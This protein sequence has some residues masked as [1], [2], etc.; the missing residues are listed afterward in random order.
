MDVG[1]VG[2]M[3]GGIARWKRGVGGQGL[4]TA[5]AYAFEGVCDCQR[6][7]DVADGIAKASQYADAEVTRFTV[8]AQHG[9]TRDQLDR[10][11]LRKWIDGRDPHTGEARGRLLQRANNDLLFDATVNSPKSLSIAA[12]LDDDLQAGLDR[13]H[14]RIRDRAIRLW[15]REMNSRRGKDGKEYMPLAQIEVVELKH[16][17]SR[18]L[19]PHAHRHMWLNAK[20]LGNDGRWTSVDSRVLL[21]FQA[22]IN[23]EGD[24]AATSDPEWLALLASKGLTVD[25]DTGEIAELAHLTQPLSRRHQQI[26]M[27]RA[28]RLAQW[29]ADHPGMSPSPADL[30]AIDK[31]AWAHGRPNK[32]SNFDELSWRDTVLDEIRALDSDTAD[33][34]ATGMPSVMPPVLAGVPQVS[35]SDIDRF[36]VMALAQADQR[37]MTASARFAEWDV[38]AAA[39]RVIA[40]QGYVTTRDSLDR[41]IDDVTRHAL[42]HYVTDLSP[43]GDTPAH[44]RRFVTTDTAMLK[45]RVDAALAELARRPAT[46]IVVADQLVD[47]IADRVTEHGL[48]DA[49]RAAA[50]SIACGQPLVTV[51]GPAGAG[52]TSML[53]VARHLLQAQ[54]RRMMIVAPTKK[55][56]TVAA[57]E[58]GSFA[59][60]VHS[61][62]HQA[63]WR[64]HDDEA[65]RARWH[66]LSPGD[67]DPQ[68]GSPWQ[69]PDLHLGPDTTI[70]IDEAGMLDLH[71]AA[72][73]IE[74]ANE[75]GVNL[76]WVGDPEQV[77]PVGHSGAMVMAQRHARIDTELHAVHRFRNPDGSADT[78]WAALSKRL[79]APKSAEDA[80]QIAAELVA[81]DRV[82]VV[83]SSAEA[84]LTLVNAWLDSHGAGQT[85]AV[86]VSTNDEAQLINDAIQAERL[87]RESLRADRAAVGMNGQR[88]LVGDVVQT[89]RNDRAAEVENRA[90]WTVARITDAGIE[91]ES[92]GTDKLRRTITHAYAADAVHLGYATTAH[93]VQ[94]E[95]VQRAIVGP[96][97]TGGG[98]YVGLTRGKRHNEC[99]VVASDSDAAERELAQQMLRG[100]QE[101]T[102]DES[103]A[104]VARELAAAATELTARGIAPE[105]WHRRRHGQLTDLDSAITAA[106]ARIPHSHDEL[107]AMQDEADQ[108]DQS[109]I[110]MERELAV[111][112]STSDLSAR[113]GRPLPAPPVELLELRTKVAKLR[114]QLEVWTRE[115]RPYVAEHDALITERNIRELVLSPARAGEE[116]AQRASW[117]R[118]RTQQLPAH[119]SD[120]ATDPRALPTRPEQTGPSLTL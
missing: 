13:L 35:D 2:A 22:I 39:M 14:D 15:Q 31:W 68:S 74:L 50:T 23:A 48:D 70:V 51:V 111:A 119:S 56:A 99:V 5:T 10:A 16:D 108:L 69:P 45:T 84:T 117:H 75:T 57:R 42:T 27:A 7:R 67:I 89:R 94:G 106:A 17:R 1:T 71:A 41:V 114:D 73:L 21:R 26:E 11:Q 46:S 49:Q 113:D 65:G 100:H 61:L 83:D 115:N 58:T 53:T 105:P 47:D 3:R 28:T 116:D 19:D 60:S 18:A 95:T 101:A 8:S 91:L 104:A 81:R 29:H 12:M 80:A 90:L 33:R 109:R 52:K 36:A 25:R 38:K 88:L 92:Q 54:Q 98:L 110:V 37:A 63:G 97:V 103:R 62:L 64:W 87:N 40:S 34:L 59:F 32:P 20:V 93:G 79:R 78:G 112:L 118:Q 96:G 66:R 43:E 77:Q 85:A 76:A 86:I 24:I 9:V 44:V 120:L 55:A 30:R 107:Q 72:A 6:A 4:R 102:L 82:R